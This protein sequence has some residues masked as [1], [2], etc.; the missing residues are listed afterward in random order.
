MARNLSALSRATVCMGLGEKDKAIEWLKKGYAD[1][2][3]VP[4]LEALALQRIQDSIRFAPTRASP[5][6]CGA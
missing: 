4:I 1:R 5:T 6:C 3:I 2:E